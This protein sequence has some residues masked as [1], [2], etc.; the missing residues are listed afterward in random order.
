[1]Y[2]CRRGVVLVAVHHS[3]S[4]ISAFFRSK[5]SFSI[6]THDSSAVLTHNGIVTGWFWRHGRTES[7]DRAGHGRLLPQPRPVGRSRCV[8]LTRTP[9]LT[10]RASA[11]KGEGGQIDSNQS[12]PNHNQSPPNHNQ[13]PPNHNQSHHERFFGHAESPPPRREKGN[14]N[15]PNGFRVKTGKRTG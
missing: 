1:M 9:S 10:A 6:V 5:D 4:L 13:S 3:S 14:D 7:M 2:P 15:I 11:P 12:P 8:R